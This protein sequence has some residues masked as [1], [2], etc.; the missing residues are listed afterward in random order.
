MPKLLIFES[1]LIRNGLPLIRR[2]YLESEDLKA[3]PTL[4]GGFL[5]A[6]QQFTA[7]TFKDLPTLLKM[8]K[9][10]ACLKRIDWPSDNVLLYA[11]CDGKGDPKIIQ[12]ALAKIT[13]RLVGW[14]TA[15]QS[16]DTEDYKGLF[17]IFDE[18]FSLLNRNYADSFVDWLAEV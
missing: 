13:K 5:S 17:P 1:G 14:E 18:E 2:Q 7:A 11:I 12:N 3:N 6:I 15:L 16:I 4:V 10:M 8:E 9:Y